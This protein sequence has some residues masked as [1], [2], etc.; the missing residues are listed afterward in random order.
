VVYCGFNL[1]NYAGGIMSQDLVDLLW[2]HMHNYAL[3]VN[4]LNLHHL[5]HPNH[6]IVHPSLR[7]NATLLQYKRLTP[8]TITAS[9][10]EMQK[11]IL[12]K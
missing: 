5:T 4:T 7:Q 10:A 12:Q 1:H 8:Q 6:I 9:F 3:W 2:F 11:Y